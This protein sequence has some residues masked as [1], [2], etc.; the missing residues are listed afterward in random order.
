MSAISEAAPYLTR[1]RFNS[2]P[3]ENVFCYQE[4]NFHLPIFRSTIAELRTCGSV[5]ATCCQLPLNL[6]GL[7]LSLGITADR[8]SVSE[9]RRANTA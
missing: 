1:V 3:S 9:L 8:S 5:G 6:F 4:M 7:V 2:A